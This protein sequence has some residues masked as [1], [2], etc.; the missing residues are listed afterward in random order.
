MIHSQPGEVGRNIRQGN[1]YDV[2]VYK[3]ESD[4]HVSLSSAGGPF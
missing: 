2:Y 1:E 3:K 4:W